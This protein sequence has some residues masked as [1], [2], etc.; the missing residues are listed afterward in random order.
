[1]H[2]TRRPYR[3]PI[4]SD[5]FTEDW[6][7]LLCFGDLDASEAGVPFFEDH[8]Q[9]YDTVYTYGIEGT[10]IDNCIFNNVRWGG[11]HCVQD[12]GEPDWYQTEDELLYLLVAPV[13]HGARGIFVRAVDIT[14]LC[15]GYDDSP[16]SGEFRYPALLQDWGPSLDT[17]DVDMFERG[18]CALDTLTGQVGGGPDLLS[19]LVSD[20]WSILDTDSAENTV[21]DY[22]NFIALRDSETEDMILMVVNDSLYTPEYDESIIFPGTREVDY[23]VH[24]LA[25]FE[26][27][28]ERSDPPLG[29]NFEGMEPFTASLYW[30]EYKW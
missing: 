7:F 28:E 30:F 18:L 2:H 19:A 13:V 21:N 17:E 15:G 9:A 8:H 14:L 23:D 24:H 25:G 3:A 16:S 6:E 26:C 11:R 1:V 27:T 20:D 5:P 4:L 29:L 22:L 12:S 10:A